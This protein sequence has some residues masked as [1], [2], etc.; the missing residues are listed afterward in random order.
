[1]SYDC[2]PVFRFLNWSSQFAIREMLLGVIFPWF[3]LWLFLQC[4]P[5]PLIDAFFEV[6]GLLTWLLVLS[7][8]FLTK[9][10]R[11]A[12]EESFA[13]GR[14]LAPWYLRTLTVYSLMMAS[15]VLMVHG[16]ESFGLG[17][18]CLT[19][20]DAAFFSWMAVFRNGQPELPIAK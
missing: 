20:E 16:Y 2:H 8:P 17:L 9:E 18:A 14:C 11:M 10:W 5:C 15:L 4:P 7:L 1:M 12:F 13:H 3:F 6:L 19:I